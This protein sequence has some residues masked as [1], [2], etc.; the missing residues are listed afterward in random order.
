MYDQMCHHDD[1]IAECLLLE[2]P[3]GV[4]RLGTGEISSLP[5]LPTLYS[6]LWLYHTRGKL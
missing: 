5:P 2:S 3:L 4:A 1:G 6:A